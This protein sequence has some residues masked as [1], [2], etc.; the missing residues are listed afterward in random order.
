M[1]ANKNNQETVG[2]KLPHA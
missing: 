2:Q 1:N